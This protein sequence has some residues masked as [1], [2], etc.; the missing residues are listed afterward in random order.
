MY[1]I[2]LYGNY[3]MP[4]AC[5]SLCMNDFMAG[6]VNSISL[7]QRKLCHLKLKQEEGRSATNII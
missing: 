5:S 3:S 1:L 2:I 7:V 4:L 6:L